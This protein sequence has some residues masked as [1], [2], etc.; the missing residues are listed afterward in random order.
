M[1]LRMGKDD[2]GVD[3]SG[4]R[5]KKAGEFSSFVEKYG[6]INGVFCLFSFVN[7]QMPF[8]NLFRTIVVFYNPSI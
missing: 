5:A 8:M 6:D 3:Y 2:N 1:L 4:Y 7:R